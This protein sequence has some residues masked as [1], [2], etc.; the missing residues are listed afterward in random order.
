MSQFK[1]K[2]LLDLTAVVL[3]MISLLSLYLLFS[4]DYKG[5]ISWFVQAVHKP[6]LQQ[7][8]SA[9]LSTQQFSLLRMVALL[10]SLFCFMLLL[11]YFKKREQLVQLTAKLAGQVL[12]A[13]VTFLKDLVPEKPLQKTILLALL[14]F[15]LLRSIVTIIYYPI[16]FD[17][18]DTYML[19][20]SQ[21]PLVSATFYPLP[22]NHILFSIITSITSL[23]PVDPVYTLRL[24]LIPIGLLCMLMM[25]ALLKKICSTQSALIGLSF[26]ISLYPLFIYSFLARG[27]LLLL[28]FYILSLYTILQICILKSNRKRHFYLFTFAAVGGL[29]TIPSFLYALSGLLLFAA[30]GLIVQKR[31]TAL[32][33]L[34]K[35]CIIIA[36]ITVTLYLPVFISAKW[37]LLKPYLNPV[38]EKG[39]TAVA[40]TSS[41]SILA[42]AFLSP[43]N[44]LAILTGAFLVLGSF[45]VFMSKHKTNRM[46][47]WFAW[48]QLILSFLVFFVFKQQ[49]PPKP[50]MHFAVVSALLF[51]AVVQLLVKQ[52]TLP[53]FILIIVSLLIVSSGT[54]AAYNYKNSNSVATGYNSVS[55]LCERFLI[56]NNVTEVYTENSYFKTMIDYYAI[57]NKLQV[58]IYNSRPTSQLYAAFDSGK[59]YDMIIANAQQSK[60]AP[61]HYL[62]DTVIK[63]HNTIVLLIRK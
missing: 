40:F 29:Y 1:S 9:F 57:K 6:H 47:V 42:K 55:K 27:Y 20:S 23:L 4:K 62:Y 21:G 22:N 50:W 18:A 11:Y 54:I 5:F 43:F 48:L 60:L 8:A 16:D 19:F 61:L 49:F 59:K 15:Y 24:P 25:Y 44:P 3:V 31:T 2:L 30:A 34:F 17:E 12:F 7:K 46:I 56:N 63:Q 39:T 37:E 41:Y 45:A 10:F 35:S 52:K 14:L 33:G 38:Y 36:L 32:I 13:T 51:T 26:F 28:F 58:K 53:S